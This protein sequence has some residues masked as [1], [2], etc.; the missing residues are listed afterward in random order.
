MK[1]PEPKKYLNAIKAYKGGLSKIEGVDKIYKL[2]SNENPFGPSSNAIAHITGGG[3]TENLPRVFG[4]RKVQA[5]IYKNS[6]ERPEIFHWLQNTG[7][8]EESEMLKTFNCGIGMILVV[9][10]KETNNLLNKLQELGEEPSLIG[11][12][13]HN[14]NPETLVIYK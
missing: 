9:N 5:E 14:E 12:I 8:V 4:S 13:I 2:S 10:P 3:I 7:N 6:W 1:K 11:K